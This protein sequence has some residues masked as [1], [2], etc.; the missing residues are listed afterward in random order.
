MF[1]ILKHKNRGGGGGGGSAFLQ[2]KIDLK[3][4]ILCIY[5]IYS[6]TIKIRLIL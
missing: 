4:N 2:C 3:S 5:Y 6:S 1:A